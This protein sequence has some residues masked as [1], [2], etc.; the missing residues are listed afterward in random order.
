MNNKMNNKNKMFLS[1]VLS[2]VF[3]FAL[4]GVYT[5]VDGF[6]IGR[7]PGNIG[8]AAISLGFPIASV[9]LLLLPI[10]FKLNGVWAAIPLAQICAFIIAVV[11]KCKLDLPQKQNNRSY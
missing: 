8:L 3:A 6:F 7:K 10:F 11:A 4:S 9:F 2:S 1:Y 5:I